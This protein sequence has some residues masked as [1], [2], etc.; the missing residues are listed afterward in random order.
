MYP[1]APAKSRLTLA[2]V[3]GPDFGYTTAQLATPTLPLAVTPGGTAVPAVPPLGNTQ[4][5]I[6]GFFLTTPGG[7]AILVAAGLIVLSLAD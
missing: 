7:V 5:R 3:Y 1:Y 2:D 4:E 6:A